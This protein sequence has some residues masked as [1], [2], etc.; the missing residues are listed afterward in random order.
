MA[1]RVET[2]ALVVQALT[3]Y[4]KTD[5]AQCDPKLVTDA[6]LFLLKQKD[7]YGVWYNAG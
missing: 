2:T 1:G 3:L 7:R 4:C 5:D 6:L